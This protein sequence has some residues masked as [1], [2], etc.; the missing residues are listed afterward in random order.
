ME[1]GEFDLEK[2]QRM[3]LRAIG[4]IQ[5]LTHKA[6]S[7]GQNTDFENLER[8]NED[9]KQFVWKHIQAPEILDYIVR[10]PT[11]RYAKSEPSIFK[12]MVMPAWWLF[13]GRQTRA[14]QRVINQAHEV[15]GHYSNLE[16]LVGM[17]GED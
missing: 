7:S 12:V 11:I 1:Q 6:L 10:I 15:K 9:F 4:E 14:S 3:L 13:S 17:M 2:Q 8:A 16:F 5:R